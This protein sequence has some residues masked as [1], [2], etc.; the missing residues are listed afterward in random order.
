MRIVEST[1]NNSE[2]KVTSKIT[3][4]TNVILCRFCW[5]AIFYCKMISFHHFPFYSLTTSITLCIS[6]F[7]STIVNLFFCFESFF[8]FDMKIK[9][10]VFL[11]HFLMAHRIWMLLHIFRILNFRDSASV[12]T[13]IL[14]PTLIFILSSQCSKCT[15]SI[16][17]WIIMALSTIVGIPIISLLET[18]LPYCIQSR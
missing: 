17:I 5:F 14:P 11:M 9:F 15:P 16:S 6:L 18:S 12:L 4:T 13:L 8:N 2:N 10:L 3:V 1:E 7:N